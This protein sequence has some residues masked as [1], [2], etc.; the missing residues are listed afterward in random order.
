MTIPPSGMPVPDSARKESNSTT[1][2]KTRNGNQ[3]EPVTVGEDGWLTTVKNE[4]QEM[5]ELREQI[6]SRMH[7]T[8]RKKTKRKFARLIV[9]IQRSVHSAQQD[10]NKQRHRWSAMPSRARE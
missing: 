4:K 5:E 6:R 3:G 9:E 10:T 1:E 7:L 8:Y 2:G